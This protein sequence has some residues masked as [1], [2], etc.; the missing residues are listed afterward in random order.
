VSRDEVVVD[1]SQGEGGGQI[2]RTSLTLSMATGRPF[3]IERIRAGRKKPGLLRQHLTAVRAAATISAAAVAGDEPGSLSLSFQPGE[4]R[5]G[6]YHFA[7]GTAGSAALVLQ[8]VLP[9]LLLA[10]AASRV[11]VEGGTH[12]PA[13]P[14]FEFLARSFLP[15]L[16]A[17]GAA[18]DLRLIRRGFYPAGGGAIEAMIPPWSARRP[19]SL[20]ERGPILERRA[21]VL[22]AHLPAHIAE[23]EL[24]VVARR[25]GLE[26][27]SCTV[28]QAVDSAGP[29]N[30]V[31][32]EIAS[33][34][35]TEVFASFGEAGVRAEAVA[36]AAADLARKY[37]AAG[38]PVG[39]HLA[40]QLLLPMALGAG[41]RF[42]TLPLSRHAQTNAD[43]I[44]QFTDA[45][46]SHE[47]AAD[48]TVSVVV[49]APTAPARG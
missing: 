41:G 35:V 44:R 21:T 4:V 42:R 27:D 9:A 17:M 12:N 33:A 37:L 38:V 8:T 30:V 16:R 32:V 19:L 7:V 22:L 39:C 46:I 25:L 36:G 2:L 14:P 11:V 20:V 1:G 45:A 31:L 23:R 3:R 24:A 40:D 15:V 34:Q 6:E 10:P 49:E 47:S 48:R 18:A 13:A 29:G 26:A 5:G 28:Q 43:V